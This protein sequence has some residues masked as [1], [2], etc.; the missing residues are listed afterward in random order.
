MALFG[1]AKNKENHNL[2]RQNIENS[3][4]DHQEYHSQIWPKT[5]SAHEIEYFQTFAE[6]ISFLNIWPSSSKTAHLY[7]RTVEENDIDNWLTEWPIVSTIYLTVADIYLAAIEAFISF[8]DFILQ[9]KWYFHLWESFQM[10]PMAA[11]EAGVSKINSW[12]NV[13]QSSF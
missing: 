5:T 2:D 6:L 12:C 9:L 3:T 13:L 11:I 4:P 7:I 10:H 1:W 8:A